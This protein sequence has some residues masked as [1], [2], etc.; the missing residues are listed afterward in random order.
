MNRESEAVPRN[1]SAARKSDWP[2]FI[3]TREQRSNGAEML[4]AESRVTL[5]CTLGPFGFQPS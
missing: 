1:A 2:N 4:N 3:P 5:A